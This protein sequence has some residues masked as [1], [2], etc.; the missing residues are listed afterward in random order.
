[1][2]THGSTFTAAVQKMQRALV[3]FHIRG[4]KTNIPFLENVFRHPEFLS[5]GATTSFIERHP[6]LFAFNTRDGS[7]ASKLLQYLGE[8]VC[9]PPRVARRCPG[10][11]ARTLLHP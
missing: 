2:I 5:G 1:M 10:A 9:P 3:E 8:L 7:Q 11:W 6:Q 4:V